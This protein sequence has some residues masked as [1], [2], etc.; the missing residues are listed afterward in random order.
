MR[1]RLRAERLM[2]LMKIVII[3]D[4]HSNLS[5]LESLPEHDYDQ[6]WC[7]GDLVD[8]GPKPRE[9]I[10]WIEDRATV[11]VCGNHDHAVGFN[12][13]PQCSAPF[14]RLAAETR[15]FTQDVCTQNDVQFLRRLPLHRELIVNSTSFYLVHAMPTDPLFGYC[16]ENSERWQTE[17]GWTDADVLVVGHT[18]TPFTR[19]IGKTTIVNPGS[20]GQPKTGRP[21]ACYALW[22]DGEISLKEYTYPLIDTIRE[23]RKMP[24]SPDDQEALIAVLETG[25]LPAGDSGSEEGGAA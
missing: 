22:E 15:R 24:I 11:I 20:V 17:I 6:L 13:N 10:R 21:L 1:A 16:P 8:Y 14:R 18:H 25:K 7:I 9:V 23:I 5:A 19:K 3:S 12:A 4:I 2:R